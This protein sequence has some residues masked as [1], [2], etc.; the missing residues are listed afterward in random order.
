MATYKL[1]PV[2]W[3]LGQILLP[4]HFSTLHSSILAELRA[5]AAVAGVPGFGIAEL[6]WHDK[7]LEQGQLQI[8]ALTA[9]LPSGLLIHV[10][11]SG[12]L[13]GLSL[14]ATGLPKVKV[15]LH[16]L[17]EPASALGNPLYASEPKTVRRQV[18]S[19]RLSTQ[20]S[21]ER[22]LETLLLGEFQCEPDRRWVIEPGS[23]PPLLQVGPNPFLLQQ[24][25]SLAKR[26]QEF[27]GRLLDDM[28]DTLLRGGYLST[29]SGCLREVCVVRSLLAEIPTGV[30]RHPY[31][32]FDA[33]RR[34]YFE[35]CAFH[36]RQPEQP[37]FPY[38]HEAIAENFQ[39]LFGYLEKNLIALTAPRRH[40]E[41]TLRDG[42]F[43]LPAWPDELARA[44]KVYLLVSRNQ[45]HERIPMDAVKIASPDR[46]DL[47]HGAALRGVPFES[48]PNPPSSRYFIEG[49]EFYELHL[50]D[51]WSQVLKSQGLCFYA[52]GLLSSSGV[53]VLLYFTTP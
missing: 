1:A 32:L 7:A 30:Y 2:R 40:V 51:E 22:S 9:V 15:Y 12:T 21:L 36:E 11:G 28:K 45:R 48:I 19:L 52:S 49:M 23:C 5:R 20:P 38:V 50:G 33:L 14:K 31:Y 27:Q 43:L 3:E 4:E 35:I 42:R 25:Q 44:E 37:C 53:R 10:P 47:V 39:R 34:L 24:L 8:Q 29:M 46:L 26:L 13:E 16:V 18:L 6:I 17:D 41:L